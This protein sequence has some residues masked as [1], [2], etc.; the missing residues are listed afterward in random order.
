MSAC[1]SPLRRGMHVLWLPP[2]GG[3]SSGCRR[4]A[5]G[6]LRRQGGGGDR[7]ELGMN[8]W[9]AFNRRRG[10]VRGFRSRPEGPRPVTHEAVQRM[11]LRFGGVGL[12]PVRGRVV[13]HEDRGA[14]VAVTLD[15]MRERER[16]AKGREEEEQC[17]PDGGAP[18]SEPGQHV[19][20]A[21][22]PSTETVKA[23]RTGARRARVCTAGGDLESAC[24]RP[25]SASTCIGRCGPSSDL[26]SN[27]ASH[28]MF[29]DAA[30]GP[31]R[32]S[33]VSRDPFDALSCAACGC[34][35]QP[36]D[37]T[38]HWTS[39]LKPEADRTRAGDGRS[40]ADILDFAAFLDRA[41]D[42]TPGLASVFFVPSDPVSF[43]ISRTHP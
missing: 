22:P 10:L 21:Y 33:F 23:A 39:A 9:R 17:R 3:R 14:V 42:M 37:P 15:P 19:D 1:A 43:P 7:E 36:E 35:L 6:R 11:R 25:P 28:P 16:P 40:A 32:T 27:P 8:S 26:F 31:T 4:R 41:A 29:L 2:R 12:E 30:Q 5:E 38:E 20:R 13:L 34:R 24:W 18:A